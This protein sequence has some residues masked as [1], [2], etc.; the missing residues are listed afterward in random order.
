MLTTITA[1]GDGVSRLTRMERIGNAICMC[2]MYP[3]GIDGTA[4][5]SGDIMMAEASVTGF[6]A[7]C[8]G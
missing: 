1:T 7:D 3:L 8:S 2:N 6:S 4:V 5:L